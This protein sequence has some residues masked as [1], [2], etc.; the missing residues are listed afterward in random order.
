[1]TRTVDVPELLRPGLLEG[2]SVLIAG[3]PAADSADAADTPG[4]S[5]GQR[6]L[7]G[8][9]SSACASLGARVSSCS[10][11]GEVDPDA[12]LLV[13][14][15]DGLFTASPERSAREALRACLDGAWET[16]QAVANGAF[17]E[18]GRAGRIVYVAPAV[19]RDGDGPEHAEAARAGL[20]NLSRTLSIEWARYA[21]TTAT[22]A[23]GPHTAPA[24]VAMLVA[25]LGSPA[26]AYFSGCM[27]DLRGPGALAR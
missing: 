10:P 14:D 1:M 12:D 19:S 7:A 11:Q 25:Y 26:G 23:P 13:V 9:V 17:I 20:E 4:A 16:T 24:E 6:S 22:I 27:F 3:D 18:P 5:G 8:A 15:G 2:V 21:I